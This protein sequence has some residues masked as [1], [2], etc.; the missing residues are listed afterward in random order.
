MQVVLQVTTRQFTWHWDETV[1]GSVESQDVNKS[2]ASVEESTYC[3]RVAARVLIYILKTR[4][5]LR[6]VCIDCIARQL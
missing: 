4:C 1:P 6:V 5:A 3:T 2:T